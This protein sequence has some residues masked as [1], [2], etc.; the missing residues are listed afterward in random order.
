MTSSS[1]NG[2]AGREAQRPSRFSPPPIPDRLIA[3]QPGLAHPARGFAGPPQAATPVRS[4]STE[5]N[6]RLKPLTGNWLLYGPALLLLLRDPPAAGPR[7][8]ISGIPAAP[9]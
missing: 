5:G 6:H 9:G 2:G 4:A 7:N 8:L 3:P 1:E